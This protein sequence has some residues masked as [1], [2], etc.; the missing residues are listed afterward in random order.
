MNNTAARLAAY[1]LL[2]LGS[3]AVHLPGQDCMASA[4]PSSTYYGSG[5][6]ECYWTTRNFRGWIPTTVGGAEALPYSTILS[7]HGF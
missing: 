6:Q 3:R 7:D 2:N 5:R 4:N 1:G